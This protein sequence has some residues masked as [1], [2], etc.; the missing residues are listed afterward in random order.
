ML[1]RRHAPGDGPRPISTQQPRTLDG[2]NGFNVSRRGIPWHRTQSVLSVRS[3]AEHGSE[4]HIPSL[5]IRTPQ[6]YASRMAS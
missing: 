5:L 3:H 1:L 2:V 4:S 6:R